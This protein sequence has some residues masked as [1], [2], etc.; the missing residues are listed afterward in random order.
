M[1]KKEVKKQTDKIKKEEPREESPFAK[2]S[3]DKSLS[4]KAMGDKRPQTSKKVAE[5]KKNQPATKK[6]KAGQKLKKSEKKG[7]SK[8][9]REVAKLIEKDKIY[10]LEEALE[11]I[12]KTTTTKFD[13][14]VEAHIRL[15]I[16]L[17]KSEQQVR[18]MVA[19][20][21][22]L[23]KV[24]KIAV[25]V[26]PEKEKEAKEAKADY[27]GEKDLVEK[28]EKGFLDF[29]I[30]MA[31]PSVMG[32]LAKVAK[33]LGPKGLMPSPK[34][35][36]VTPDIK[37]TIEEFK[38]GKIEFRADKTGVIHQVIGKVSFEANK[39]QD[40]FQTLLE[41]VQKAKPEK[42]KGSYILSLYLCTTMGPSVKIKN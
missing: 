6:S 30:L 24:L 28:I 39:L 9:Y 14:S 4:A 23:G 29:D 1:A 27:V 18:G 17:S 10:S 31:D 19:L 32:L 25:V 41:A 5:I 36:T 7:R 21:H 16:D 42:I 12:K 20:P 11:L 38:R 22:S 13:S 33:I 26:P 37:K 2:A 3:G 40:N 15:G 35:G 34:S 8:K